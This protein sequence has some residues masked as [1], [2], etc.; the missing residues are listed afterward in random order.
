M[1]D[2]MEIATALKQS[3]FLMEGTTENETK[4][5]KFGF[6]NILLGTLTASVQKNMSIGEETIQA[7]AGITRA[8]QKN[9]NAASSFK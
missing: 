4:E 6:L 3:A 2:I 8:V 1:K 5:Q 7:G 9:F